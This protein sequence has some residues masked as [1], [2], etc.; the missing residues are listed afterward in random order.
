[1]AESFRQVLQP[2]PKQ[3]GGAAM[4]HCPFMRVPYLEL[5][6]PVGRVVARVVRRMPRSTVLPILSGPGRGSKWI[7]RACEANSWYGTYERAKIGRLV[8]MLRPDTVFFD[9]GANA[10]YYSV[11]A[12]PRCRQVYAFEPLPESLG[13]LRRHIALNQLANCT[14]IEAAAGDFDGPV[15]FSKSFTK[16]EGQISDDGELSVVSVR[17]DTFC[18]THP[19]PDLLKIDVEG[20][21]LAVLRGAEQLLIERRP[22]IFLATHSNELDKQ[23]RSF[24]T[25]RGYKLEQ[26]EPGEL[27]AT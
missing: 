17:L 11:I 2:P 21:E 5:Q 18:Q 25:E 7:A 6:I 8:K 4:V 12:A 26:L 19:A 15:H 14:A 3:I 16:Y 10:G 22:A 20:A 27:I 23:C 24:L 1:V 13:Y 9:L